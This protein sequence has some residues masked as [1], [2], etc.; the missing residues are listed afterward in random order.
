M[1]VVGIMLGCLLIIGLVEYER[2]LKIE[3]LSKKVVNDKEDLIEV[4]ENKVEE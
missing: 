1:K 3:I 4:T 2:N